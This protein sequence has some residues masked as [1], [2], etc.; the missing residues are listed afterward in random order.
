MSSQLL[1]R[2][3]GPFTVL[4][5]AD[6]DFD[7]TVS[8]EEMLLHQLA[9]KAVDEALRAR[10][11]GRWEGVEM[12]PEMAVKVVAVGGEL[13]QAYATP[14]EVSRGSTAWVGGNGGI[15]P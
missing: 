5:S 3:K 10:S 8:D 13:L 9:R 7:A 12:P 1:V 2:P 14:G 4:D 6:K 15:Q 11:L